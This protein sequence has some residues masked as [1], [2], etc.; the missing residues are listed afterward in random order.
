MKIVESLP[1]NLGVVERCDG[2]GKLPVP[3]ASY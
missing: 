3:G 1:L 2:A